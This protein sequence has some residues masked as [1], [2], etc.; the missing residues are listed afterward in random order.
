MY[1]ALMTVLIEP[2][3]G[4]EKTLCMSVYGKGSFTLGSPSQQT[5]W[6]T[7]W[8]DGNLT[9]HFI[10]QTTRRKS[11]NRILRGSQLTALKHMNSSGFAT[12]LVF[13]NQHHITYIT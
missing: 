2:G 4:R 6:H 3:D 10:D 9:F 12:Y 13:T 1:H 7:L 11:K 8:C 5:A